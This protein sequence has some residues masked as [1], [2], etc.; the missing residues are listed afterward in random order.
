M[1]TP[2]NMQQLEELFHEAVGLVPDE[3]ANFMARIRD[4][5]PELVAELESLIAA[6]EQPDSLIDAPAYE[7]A[8]EIISDT[9][10]ALAPGQV[11]GHY[12]IIEPLGKGGMGEVYLA[13]DTKLDRQVALKLLPAEF[14][15]HKERL[16]RFIQE[17]KTASSLNH[18]NIIT[19][20]EIGQT[21][22]L[23]FIATE[24]IAG[25]TLKQRLARAPMALP[26]ILDVL[27]QTAN[28][29]QA[30]H[31]AGIIHRDIKPEN[32]MLRP[33][34][35]V[36]VLDFGLAKLTKEFRPSSLSSAD[37]ETDTMHK[38]VPGTVLGTIKYMSPEQARGQVLDQR[39]DVFSL[40]VVLYEMTA[41]RIPFSGATGMDT[42]VSILEKEAAPLD[43][44]APETPGELQR[45]V[46]KALRKDREE[47]YQTIKDLLID[48]KS[49]KE[50]LAFSQKLGRSRS[51]MV[52][53]ETTTTSESATVIQQPA[54]STA[55]PAVV[56]ASVQT[57]GKPRRNP[58]LIVVAFIVLAGLL[59]GVA[60]WSRRAGPVT[61][62]PGPAP[63][64]QRTVNYWITVQ[65]YRDG[66]PFQ[67]P[68]RLRDDIN[69]EKDYQLRLSVNSSQS[70]H[71][72]LLNEGPI[73]ADQSPT[74]NVM[75][76]STT[77]N[78]G[79]ALL[80][81]NQ[82][83]QIPDQTW[84]KFD[85]QQGTEKIWLVWAAQEVPELEAVKGFANPKDRGVISSP[86][87]RTA[88]NQFLKAHATPGP[89]VQR[90]EEK[91]ETIIKVNSEIL[92]H[93]IKLE[94]H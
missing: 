84:F 46:S 49:F 68:F 32:I 82:Q 12:Q 78:H 33:D 77:T 18:P 60:L 4:S 27:I 41:G 50:E 9:Q 19:I 59:I 87:L 86:G 83:I 71:L 53:P 51:A 73:G 8:A 40:G 61:A 70:G 44:Y 35:Y 5:N 69:F 2:E 16:R 92:V 56:P 58:A 36:K 31:A 30:A 38:T 74:F 24:F 91:K 80:T 57:E 7:A 76:P 48:L 6:H 62:Q 43:Q 45:I 3:R 67:D 54:R 20:H 23:H 63:I 85:E 55:D 89:V 88:V 66:K 21:E 64:V 25:Q 90:D 52:E 22:D 13:S 17:A 47:R 10:P 34:G 72:Y 42:I 11:V 39:T 79:S 37:S 81:Q 15:N 14:T 65:K 29:L 26:E 94:H 28:A 75:F 1:Y 93:V